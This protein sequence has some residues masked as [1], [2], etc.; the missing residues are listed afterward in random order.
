M[1]VL[2][3]GLGSD[4]HTGYVVQLAVPRDTFAKAAHKVT[5]RYSEFAALHEALGRTWGRQVELPKLPAKRL[6]VFGGSLSEK[7]IEE[8]RAKLEEYL[9]L[10]VQQLNWSQDASLR[11]FLECDKWAKERRPREKPSPRDSGAVTTPR[12]APAG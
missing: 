12:D 5:H 6:S 10:L 9:Q 11:A 7:Q 2:Q 1:F 4:A 8:R 3:V